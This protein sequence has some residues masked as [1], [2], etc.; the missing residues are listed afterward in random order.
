MQKITYSLLGVIL[1]VMLSCKVINTSNIES[2]VPLKLENSLLWKIEGN[3]LSKPSYLFG[4]IHLIKADK[5][6]LPSGFRKAFDESKSVVFEIDIDKMNDISEQ[7][8]FL[9]KLMMKGDTSLK[10]LITD[11]E[12]SKVQK[13][14]NE[15]HLPLFL[16]EKIKPMFLTMFTDGDFNPNS[17]QSGE[18][19]SYE[20]EISKLAKEN[21]KN[22]NGLETIDF[23]ISVLDSIPY[24]YQAEMLMKSIEV[25]GGDTNQTDDMYDMYLEQNITDLHQS[26]ESEDISK[27]DKILLN[28]RNNTW[29]PRMSDYMQ[30]GQTFF[31]VGA[32]HLAGNQGVIE[33]LRKKGYKVIAVLDERKNI[34]K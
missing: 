23:Q 10:D 8:K 18:Y 32:G 19:V 34:K 5:Y 25:Q 6:F 16:F 21:G 33:L 12:Y 9:P 15:K 26:I 22:I 31:A 13:Y 27:Y 4:T 20:M 29:I 14:F 7:M 11:D 3:G 30:Q 2:D 24:A 28:N 17:I 1:L